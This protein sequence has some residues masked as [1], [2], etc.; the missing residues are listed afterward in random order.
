MAKPL[1]EAV[2]DLR[3][4]VVDALDAEYEAGKAAGHNLLLRL[5]D[6]DLSMNDFDART[7]E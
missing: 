7:R 3:N 1:A 6:G 5:A 2:R 4:A